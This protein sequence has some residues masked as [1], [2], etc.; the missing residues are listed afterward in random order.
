[1]QGE[2]LDEIKGAET[3]RKT[4]PVALTA[5]CRPLECAYPPF[6]DA[7]F[8]EGLSRVNGWALCVSARGQMST[9]GF[10]LVD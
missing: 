6:M 7:Q 10:L 8:F 2:G 9:L 4:L 5:C 1:M 3:T